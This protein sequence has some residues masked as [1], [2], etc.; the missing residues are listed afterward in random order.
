[1]SLL[2]NTFKKVVVTSMILTTVLGTGG[3]WTWASLNNKIADANNVTIEQSVQQK[4]SDNFL[5][6][7]FS[8]PSASAATSSRENMTDAEVDMALRDI[9]TTG[10]RDVILKAY[11][12]GIIGGYDDRTFRTNN[13]VSYGEAAKIIINTGPNQEQ[14]N[15]STSIPDFVNFYNNNFYSP[16]ARFSTNTASTRWFS[17]YLILRQLGISFEKND[18]YKMNNPFGDVNV[19]TPFAPY[20]LFARNNNIVSWYDNGNFGPNNNVTRGELTKMSWNALVEKPSELVSQYNQIKSSTSTTQPSTPVTQPTQTRPTVTTGGSPSSTSPAPTVTNST[21]IPWA[22]THNGKVVNYSNWQTTSESEIMNF[23]KTSKLTISADNIDWNANGKYEQNYAGQSLLGHQYL[24]WLKAVGP[25][26]VPAFAAPVTFMAGLSAGTDG[27]LVI[28][29]RGTVTQLG[30]SSNG[31]TAQTITNI[32]NAIGGRSKALIAA[33]EAN[34]YFERSGNMSTESTYDSFV[35]T[36]ES[37]WVTTWSDVQQ[38]LTKDIQLQVAKETYSNLIAAGFN[39]NEWKLVDN[40]IVY[41]PSYWNGQ[42]M[43][44]ATIDDYM[45]L[46]IASQRSG[47]TGLSAV[48][49]LPRTSSTQ[50]W[51][52]SIIIPILTNVR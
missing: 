46:F 42:Y 47:V 27:G 4:T 45:L 10:F 7:I 18:F 21:S 30:H 51:A 44:K 49:T 24:E 32:Q 31:I 6:A 11:K 52:S 33:T 23:Y 19:N 9:K 14:M 22:V 50:E 35:Q 17:M 39:S 15:G 20:I 40:K 34:K 26:E 36:I 13:S 8:I 37:K 1:M 43:I 48:T 41:A 3:L 5:T 16:E 2:T 38:Y 29:Y 28:N 12:R 25:T